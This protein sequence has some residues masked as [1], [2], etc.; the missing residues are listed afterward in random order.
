MPRLTSAIRD[1]DPISLEELDERAALMRRSD[2]KYLLER[3]EFAR[4]V[5]DMDYDVLEIDGRRA[6]S[7][8]SV[9]FDSPDLRC[10]QD[11]VEGRKPRFKA[12]TRCYLDTGHS[13]FE[14]KL[15]LEDGDTDKR[16]IDYPA[17][18]TDRLNDDARELLDEALGGDVP[19]NMGVSLRTRFERVTLVPADGG[20]RI[21]CDFNI[22]L[23]RP[24]RDIACLREGLLV[25]EVKAPDGGGPTN[26]LMTQLGVEPISLSKYRTGVSLLEPEAVDP[27]PPTEAEEAF[28]VPIY[29]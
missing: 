16:Q 13:V 1:L 24:R 29:A 10:F 15:K 3:A 6:F 27:D 22:R 12:R 26:E 2:T 4:I 21:T 11:H 28:G 18:E 20:E 17:D 8:Q 25:C 14:V 7:Y 19:E 23:E 5:W 9:Y